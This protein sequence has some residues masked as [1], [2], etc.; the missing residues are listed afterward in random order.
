MSN[1]AKIG[2][3]AEMPITLSMSCELSNL[4]DFQSEN[5]YYEN[6]VLNYVK[7]KA[8]MSIF[9]SFI[10]SHFPDLDPE[11]EAIN[12][13]WSV[14]APGPGRAILSWEPSGAISSKLQQQ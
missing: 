14:R 11:L 10:Y 7:L 6:W 4:H 1:G 3:I 9:I 5:N 2:I 12:Y 13:A 8:S